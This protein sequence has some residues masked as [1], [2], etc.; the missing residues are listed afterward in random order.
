MSACF[1]ALSNPRQVVLI[2]IIATATHCELIVPSYAAAKSGGCP[3]EQWERDPF[4]QPV[5]V[6]PMTD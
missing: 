1:S 4:G 3:T 6:A 2:E 5:P